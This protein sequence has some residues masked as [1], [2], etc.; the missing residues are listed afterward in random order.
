M[1]SVTRVML[2]LMLYGSRW[3]GMTDD[4]S[5]KESHVLQCEVAGTLFIGPKLW[6]T[7]INS[8]IYDF[9]NFGETGEQLLSNAEK[10]FASFSFFPGRRIEKLPFWNNTPHISIAIP[11]A[12][13]TTVLESQ[14]ESFAAN[15]ENRK[16]KARWWNSTHKDFT[17]KTC[18]SDHVANGVG[19]NN[20]E[21]N[22][23]FCTHN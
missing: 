13:C 2:I 3:I 1:L 22:F 9:Q 7:I 4:R 5:D 18:K 19:T 17:L 15:I 8:E 21:K 12:V 14:I 20:K 6:V 11:N 23:H 10:H 16:S